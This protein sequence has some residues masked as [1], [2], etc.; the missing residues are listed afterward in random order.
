M[1]SL[2]KEASYRAYNFLA[3]TQKLLPT[4]MRLEMRHVPLVATVKT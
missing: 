4:I 1:T 2:V 3:V